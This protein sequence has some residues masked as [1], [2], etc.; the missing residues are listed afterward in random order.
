M[1]SA[2]H[3]HHIP[4]ETTVVIFY[5][6]VLG[7]SYSEKGPSFFG[8]LVTR[9]SSSRISHCP[10]SY[11][12]PSQGVPKKSAI[13]FLLVRGSVSCCIPAPLAVCCLSSLL[14]ISHHRVK[15]SANK[16][17]AKTGKIFLSKTL[18]KDV[19]PDDLYIGNT[20]VV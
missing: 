2:T 20:V 6:V 15:H 17:C 5:I 10:A 7:S 14:L 8:V 19:A 11:F 3:Q 1:M 18:A 16:V 9:C 13:T 12:V 4:V